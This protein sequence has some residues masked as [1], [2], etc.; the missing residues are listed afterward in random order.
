MYCVLEIVGYRICTRIFRMTP[1][2]D[3]C[4]F[5]EILLALPLPNCV[6]AIVRAQSTSSTD[7]EIVV[8]SATRAL[9]R[10]EL[11]TTD[12]CQLRGIPF[13][14]TASLIQ[15]KRCNVASLSI[16]Q[17]DETRAR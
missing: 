2:P 7:E 17:G 10:F 3:L 13:Y 15:R 5:Y 6:V 14:L 12:E 1:H 8:H 11:N 9:N 4:D 16:V